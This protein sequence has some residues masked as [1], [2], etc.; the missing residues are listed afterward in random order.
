[1]ARATSTSNA[2]INSD[3]IQDPTATPEVRLARAPKRHYIDLRKAYRQQI[4]I[5]WDNAFRGYLSVHWEL[6]MSLRRTIADTKQ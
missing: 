3:K 5:G 1:M 4:L 2:S 6:S